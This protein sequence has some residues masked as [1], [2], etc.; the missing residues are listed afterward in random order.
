MSAYTGYTADIREIYARYT[1]GGDG[2]LLRCV[3][4]E[5]GGGQKAT[6]GKLAR[7]RTPQ[8]CIGRLARKGTG[9]ISSGEIAG[10]P[11]I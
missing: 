1:G 3:S 6:P 10:F 8:S 4:N 2:V 5:A 11:V 7:L 9:L